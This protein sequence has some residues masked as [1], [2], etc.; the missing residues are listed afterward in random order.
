MTNMKIVFSLLCVI[1]LISACQHKD[2]ETITIPDSMINRLFELVLEG[3]IRSEVPVNYERSKLNGK[4]NYKSIQFM[5]HVSVQ[6]GSSQKWLI[7]KDLQTSTIPLFITTTLLDAYFYGS[8]PKPSDDQLISTLEYCYSLND[9]NTPYN[10]SLSRYGPCVFVEELQICV[11]TS[12]G[13]LEIKKL[14]ESVQDHD[15]D[16]DNIDKETMLGKIMN[17]LNKKVNSGT[18]F[19][20]DLFAGFFASPEIYNLIT[21][22]DGTFLWLELGSS[23]EM[24]VNEFPLVWDKWFNYKSNISVAFDAL[25]KYAYRPFSTDP[26]V[27][28]VDSGNYYYLRHFLD[29]AKAADKDVAL[30]SAWFTNAGEKSHVFKGYMLHKMTYVTDLTTAADVV[31]SITTLVLSGLVSPEIMKDQ[32]VSQIYLN[33]SAL[34]SYSIKSNFSNRP[35]LALMFFPSRYMFYW[36]VARIVSSLNVYKIEKGF[37]VE[38]MELIF[39]NLKQA[40]EGEATRFIISD[41]KRDDDDGSLYFDDF[42]GNGDLTADNKPI[43]RGEDRI[44]TTA[45]AA[46]ALMY[47]WLTFDPVSRKSHWKNGTPE[48]VKDIVDGC[49]LWLVKNTLEGKF[50]PWNA[51]HISQN[52]GRDYNSCR[53]PTN[54]FFEVPQVHV[55]QFVS[56][57][58]VIA[59]VQGYIPKNKYEAMLNTL[60]FG[61]PTPTV[62][63]GFNHPDFGDKLF[64]SSD[65][66]T[67]TVTLLA[68]SR[69]REI[70]YHC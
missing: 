16:N 54:Y 7:F 52:K 66:Y 31:N 30:P 24:Q 59:G 29:D 39:S 28:T 35:D 27:N 18:S 47:T 34:I 67:Y 17:T 53:Y 61:K 32:E 3:Q 63:K 12:A 9:V 55:L 58:R 42:L 20:L 8:I 56:L 1:S 41:V 70:V 26:F 45:M 11:P 21:D 5:H 6:S 13:Y 65:P 51:L 62:F 4:G 57:F 15:L 33:A 46:N 68:L 60:Q 43:I 48:S 10:S 38:D 44:F 50:K 69:Y 25:K 49:V 19:D 22:S 2:K 14:Q 37:P 23:I 36:T 64:W 40:M